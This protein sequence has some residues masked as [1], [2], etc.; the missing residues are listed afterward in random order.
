MYLDKQFEIPVLLIAFNRPGVT[1]QVFE[2]I[3]NI[4]PK[5]LYFAVDSYR[6]GIIN[7]YE[8]VSEVKS[9]IEGVDWDCQ[10]KTLFAHRN[11]GCKVAVSNAINWLFQNE[12]MGVILEDDCL[13]NLDFFRFCDKMLNY[14]KENDSIMSIT[15][16][17]FQNGQLRGNGSYYFSKFSQIWGWATWKRAWSK[18]DVNISSWPLSK[19]DFCWESVFKENYKRKYFEK[20][21]SQT[22][23]NEIDTWDYQWQYC[24]WENNGLIVTPNKNLIKN[25]GFGHDATHTNNL[26]HKLANMVYENLGEIKYVSEIKQN[27]EAD[28]YVFDYVFNGFYHRFPINLLLRV[29]SV[30]KNFFL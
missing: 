15:G 22:Y 12:E 19:N 21:F 16:V 4:R 25:I 17:N 20:K 10:V 18:Y 6:V 5:K 9:I 30:I 11:L 2:S 29:Y 1:K 14:Y 24:I 8:L 13:P 7:E 3:R 28:N 23:N 26:N 27:L